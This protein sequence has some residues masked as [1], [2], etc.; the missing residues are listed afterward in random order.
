MSL[1]I[2]MAQ[3]IFATACS[4]I[5]GPLYTQCAYHTKLSLIA[6]FMGP[7]WGSI[8][9]RQ[10]PGGP[11]VGPMNFAIWAGI[12][13]WPPGVTE[14]LN[15]WISFQIQY[16]IWLDLM[17]YLFLRMSIDM[18]LY[19]HALRY[20]YCLAPSHYPDHSLSDYSATGFCGMH[21]KNISREIITILITTISLHIIASTN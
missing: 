6:R 17:T 9:G 1:Y 14:D 4:V 18:Y 8:W 19:I 12:V 11:H 10:D 15:R 3:L 20:T 5:S 7:T 13:L 21:L 16:E 2:V